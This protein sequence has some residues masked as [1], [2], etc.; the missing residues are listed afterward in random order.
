MPCRPGSYWVFGKCQ[1]CAPGSYSNTKVSLKC[2]PCIGGTIAPLPGSS[3]CKPCNRGWYAVDGIKCVSSDIVIKCLPGYTLSKH[4]TDCV[5]CAPGTY[6][7]SGKCRAC[8]PGTFSSEEA[9]TKCLLCTDFGSLVAPNPGSVSCDRCDRPFSTVDGINC[10]P[11]PTVSP[12][13]RISSK[14]P[15]SSPT[16]APSAIP[17]CGAPAALPT[18]SPVT[19]CLAGYEFNGKECVACRPGSY[20]ESGKCVPCKSGTFNHNPASTKCFPCEAG[21]VANRPGLTECSKC[22]LHHYPVNSISCIFGA[23]NPGY[24]SVPVGS[25]NCKACAPG[26]Y[27]SWGVGTDN[28]CKPCEPGTYTSTKAS[29]ECLPCSRNAVA[30]NPGSEYCE[31]CDWPSKSFNGID[32]IYLELPSR[33]PVKKNFPTAIPTGG[34]PVMPPAKPS[35]PD[36][37]PM[38]RP[39]SK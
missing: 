10:N 29:T 32:C 26:T 27:S 31:P 15:S 13:P 35:K 12:T 22:P 37:S 8:A 3:Y 7:E 1:P 9:S 39:P 18:P 20:W 34:Y 30:P 6:E 19:S 33:P 28:I 36:Y 38:K 2:L 21:L 25:N 4:G 5:P 24:I 14:K 11:P 16:R 23:C 17:T